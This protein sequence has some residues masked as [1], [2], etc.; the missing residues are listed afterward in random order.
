MK[1]KIDEIAGKKFFLC[2][3]PIGPLLKSPLGPSCQGNIYTRSMVL[4]VT[5]KDNKITVTGADQ[6]SRL[7]VALP[8][9]W[10]QKVIIPFL[11]QQQLLRTRPGIGK[12]RRHQP[13][14]RPATMCWQSV[15]DCDSFWFSTFF[16]AHSWNGCP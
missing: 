8:P 2:L 16:R 4:H 14:H 11:L 3:V 9:Y 12:S 7:Q 6:N 15:F 10:N 5:R 1:G 13:H